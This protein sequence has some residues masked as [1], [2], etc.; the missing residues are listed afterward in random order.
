MEVYWLFLGL[1]TDIVCYIYLHL[2]QL[3]AEVLSTLL[4]ENDEDVDIWYLIGWAN[5]RLGDEGKDTARSYLN[6]AKKLYKKTKCQD[7]E[8]IKHIE[9]LLECLGSG[10]T[11]L[12]WSPSSQ[13]SMF[14]GHCDE[15]WVTHAWFSCLY[16]IRKKY[17]L[18]M[19]AN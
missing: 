14:K 18:V 16:H 15:I 2:L 19:Y 4:E 7:P 3:A 10:R 17:F 6:K 11:M 5:Y 8:L 12:W 9:E 1:L 13:K